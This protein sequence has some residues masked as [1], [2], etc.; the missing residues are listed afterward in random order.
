MP[1]RCSP[2]C[3]VTDRPHKV[4]LGCIFNIYLPNDRTKNCTGVSFSVDF[5]SKVSSLLTL[6]RKIVNSLRFEKKV[7]GVNKDSQT[8]K[9]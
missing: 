2:Q 1:V 4:Y 5:A 8:Q 6:I 9:R 7:F 3:S